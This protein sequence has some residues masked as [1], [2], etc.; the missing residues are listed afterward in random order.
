MFVAACAICGQCMQNNLHHH[1]DYSY[2]VLVGAILTKLHELRA[3][4]LGVVGKA[5][6]FGTSGFFSSG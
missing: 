3:G 2:A 5:T 4:K 6:A 1:V